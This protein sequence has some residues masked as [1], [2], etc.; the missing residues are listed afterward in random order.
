LDGKGHAIVRY[1][2]ALPRNVDRSHLKIVARLYYQ[3]FA[4]Y[5]LD[6]RTNGNGPAALRLAAI[7]RNL[8]L[9]GT[10]LS[11]WRLLIAEG[12]ATLRVTNRSRARQ[13]VAR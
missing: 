3:S 5:Y 8:D 4:P 7:V 1:V 13:V 2:V 9:Q 10:A 11:G 12:S 6:A